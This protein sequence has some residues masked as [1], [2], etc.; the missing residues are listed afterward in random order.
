[1]TEPVS[2]KKNL[3]RVK[4][5]LYQ[6]STMAALLD[7]VYDGDM[8]L[9]SLLE[10]GDFGLGTFNALDGEMIVAEGVVKQFRAEGVASSASGDLKTP[11]ASVTFF[12]PEITVTLDKPCNKEAFEAKVNEL[13]ANPNLFGAI[14]FTGEFE[15][16]DTRTVFCQCKP[17]PHMLDVVAKQPTFTM[18]NISGTMLGFRTPSYMQGINVAGYHLH[19][20]S[21]DG[22]HGGHVTDYIVKKGKL[23]IARISDLEIALPRT[24]EFAEADL[25]P[26]N[27]SESI[28]TA[29]GG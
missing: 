6:T 29:E 5:R 18:N 2:Q 14:R 16:V 10:H 26:E 20:L 8:T 11:F 27:L 24:K 22:K 25:S 12:E 23:E 9:D 13:L 17:Y 19:V 1:M 4:N 7:A 21:D 3:P 15:T 28:R